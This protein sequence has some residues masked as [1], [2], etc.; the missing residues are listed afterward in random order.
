VGEEGL[1]EMLADKNALALSKCTYNAIV[2]TD[3]HTYSTL[4][5]EYS[6]RLDTPRP[7][8]HYT[9]LLDELITT[10]R[11]KMGKK[12]DYQVTY[13]DP[14]YLGRYN[15]VYE[16]PRR[17]IEATGCKLVE[18][19]RNRE[20]ALCCG[21]GGGRIWMD[22]TGVKERPSERRIREAAQLDQVQVF[23]VTC[24]KDASM[25][26]DAVKTSGFENRLVVKDLIE[27]VHEAL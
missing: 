7:V 5:N 14:C 12:L 9:E 20:H 26:K 13:H 22:E 23:V 2:T 19:P 17:V 25:F 8:L 18:M 1:F 10:G 24:P 3:P 21:A 27:L 16:A 15:Q 4:K 6:S 11:L